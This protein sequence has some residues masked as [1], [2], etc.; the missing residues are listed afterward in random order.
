MVT[1]TRNGVPPGTPQERK[2][3]EVVI[4]AKAPDQEEPEREV[5]EHQKRRSHH[6]RRER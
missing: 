1:S 4:E 3:P 6:A 2:Q 5:P